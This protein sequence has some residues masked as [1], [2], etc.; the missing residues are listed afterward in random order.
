MKMLTN[1]KPWERRR[2]AGEFIPLPFR[3]MSAAEQMRNHFAFH[4]TLKLR[5]FQS[6]RVNSRNSWETGFPQNKKLPNEPI[7]DF[8]LLPANKGDSAPSAL[9]RTEKRTHL[10]HSPQ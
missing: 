9:N 7:L 8:S 4:I 10:T 3:F 6:I 5:H 1:H 2:P